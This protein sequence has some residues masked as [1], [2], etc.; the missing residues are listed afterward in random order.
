MIN[1]YKNHDG[2]YIKYYAFIALTYAPLRPKSVSS[3]IIL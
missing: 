1:I 3:V 2:G